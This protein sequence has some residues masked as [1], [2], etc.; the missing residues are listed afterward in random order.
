MSLLPAV[1]LSFLVAGI[2]KTPERHILNFFLVVT[3][4][5][6]HYHQFLVTWDPTLLLYYLKDMSSNRTNSLPSI[7]DRSILDFYRAKYNKH[8]FKQGVLS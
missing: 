2:L 7:S 6:P 3:S 4:N 1:S 8:V 5:S